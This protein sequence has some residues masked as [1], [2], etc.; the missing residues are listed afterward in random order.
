MKAEALL[1]NLANTLA[2]IKGETLK[3][4]PADVKAQAL[5]DALADRPEQWRW[6]H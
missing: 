4:T 3:D 5:V 1:D 2:D 6:K